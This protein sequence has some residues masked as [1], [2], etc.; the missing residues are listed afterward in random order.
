[1]PLIT[2]CVSSFSSWF[3]SL[4]IPICFS[5]ESVWRTSEHGRLAFFVMVI[6]LLGMVNNGLTGYYYTLNGNK[7]SYNAKNALIDKNTYYA[8]YMP[9]TLKLHIDL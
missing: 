7:K 3:R 2:L 1:M 9:Y 6:Y 4:F 5:G 8:L